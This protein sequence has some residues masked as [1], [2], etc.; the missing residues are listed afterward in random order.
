M[1]EKMKKRK[2]VGIVK[3][4]NRRIIEVTHNNSGMELVQVAILVAIAIVIGL[5]FRSQIET[6]VKEIFSK[7]SS[8]SFS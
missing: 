7:L 1:I 3:R 2:N 8:G 5:I 6:F 4:M